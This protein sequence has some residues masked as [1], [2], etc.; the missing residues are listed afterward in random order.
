MQFTSF[1]TGQITKRIIPVNKQMMENNQMILRQKL[2]VL[3]M[4]TRASKIKI[5]DTELLRKVTKDQNK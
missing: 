5:P 1:C 3:C 4:N 2:L